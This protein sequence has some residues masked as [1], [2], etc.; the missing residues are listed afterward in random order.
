MALEKKMTNLSAIEEDAVTQ[1]EGLLI[2]LKI[3]SK[4]MINVLTMMAEDFLR[5]APIVVRT[6]EGHL[7]SVQ[8]SLKLPV[9]YLID[10]IVKN[11]GQE[12][13]SLFTQN[14]VSTFCGVFEKVDDKVK[15][16]MFKLRQTWNDHFPQRKLYAIDV[17]CHQFDKNWPISAPPPSNTS[18]IHV[19]P[20]FLNTTTPAIKTLPPKVSPV[21]AGVVETASLLDIGPVPEDVDEVHLRET[22]LQKRKELL[23]LQQKKIELELMQT[24]SALESKRLEEIQS[25]VKQEK[26]LLGQAEKAKSKTYIAHQL[27]SN[28][29]A[30]IVKTGAHPSTPPQPVQ[31]QVALQSLVPAPPVKMEKNKWEADKDSSKDR[32]KDKEREN[33]RGERDRSGSRG[34]RTSSTSS[35]KDSKDHKVRRNYNKDDH[36]N[37]RSMSKSTSKSPTRPIAI[38]KEEVSDHNSS[39]SSPRHHRS[40]KSHHKKSNSGSSGLED[41]LP[42][43]RK[44]EE[45]EEKSPRRKHNRSSSK[46][47][48]ASKT[49]RGGNDHNRDGGEDKRSS[50]SK[51]HAKKSAVIK[52][53]EHE[54]NFR[55]RR[56]AV[57]KRN[58]RKTQGIDMD[59]DENKIPPQQQQQMQISSAEDPSSNNTNTI[60][61]DLRFH[62]RRGGDTDMQQQDDSPNNC[63]NNE[64]LPKK[65]R[66][67]GNGN[68]IVESLFGREDV[69]L[70]QTPCG[71]WMGP[72][73]G[74]HPTPWGPDHPRM[75]MRG[76]ADQQQW[77][78][79][80]PLLR[81]GPRGPNPFEEALDFPRQP[82]I[83]REMRPA[84]RDGPWLPNHPRM[85]Q[86]IGDQWGLAPPPRGPIGPNPFEA[87]LD[88][89]HFIPNPTEMELRIMNE[90]SG[91]FNKALRRG[92]RGQRGSRGR[93]G[94][95][96]GGFMEQHN[97][98][99]DQQQHQLME[100][101]NFPFAINNNLGNNPTPIFP[102]HGHD[103]QQRMARD[104]FNPFIHESPNNNDNGE[105]QRAPLNENDPP[106]LG[107]L[108]VSSLLEQAVSLGLLPATSSEPAAK[109]AGAE[110][111]A[112]V[113]EEA[114]VVLNDP[115][116]ESA[117]SKYQKY[118]KFQRNNHKKMMMAPVQATPPP[119]LPTVDVLL[120]SEEKNYF[121]ERRQGLINQLWVGKQCATCGLRF[122]PD[123]NA[124]YEQHLDW[125][126]RRNARSRKEKED[127]GA[128]KPQRR[129]WYY[130]LPEW[131]LFEEIEDIEERAASMFETQGDADATTQSPGGIV[132]PEECS[133]PAS[134]HTGSV[135]PQ[136]G[137]NFESYYDQDKEEW[138]LRNAV[139]DSTEGEDKDYINSSMMTEEA[140]QVDEI[141]S[142]TVDDVQNG[143]EEVTE[144]ASQQD[145]SP[146]P[147][148]ASPL[149]PQLEDDDDEVLILKEGKK[150]VL[151]EVMDIDDV[152]DEGEG[153]KE[154]ENNDNEKNKEIEI[155]PEEI[156]TT[157]TAT[158]STSDDVLSNADRLPVLNYSIISRPIS[159]P[160]VVNDDSSSNLLPGISEDSSGGVFGFALNLGNIRER[161]ESPEQVDEKRI[162]YK[163]MEFDFPKIKIE[164]PDDYDDVPDDVVSTP[165]LMAMPTPIVEL[166]SDQDPIDLT[167]EDDSVD[168]C[169]GPPPRSLHQMTSIDGNLHQE[170]YVPIIV[171]PTK[172]RINISGLDI[173]AKSPSSKDPK[174][175]DPAAA[176]AASP[177]PEKGSTSP[178]SP[179]TTVVPRS[180]EPSD[181]NNKCSNAEVMSP[182]EMKYLKPRLHEFFE[183]G[184]K[185]KNCPPKQGKKEESGLCVIS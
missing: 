2:E 83:E 161:S 56:S 108:D 99:G 53:Q 172:M 178:K 63:Q 160:I 21:V 96:R 77:G 131:I 68:V 139:V 17:R 177:T 138:R 16:Q 124:K 3:N 134:S 61:V 184:R 78:P 94:G 92:G 6:I 30:N 32:T 142:V 40:P 25:T 89:G 164:P 183:S 87:A 74:P 80:P 82:P 128:K 110:I 28:A 36:E 60:D 12:Y 181:S 22:L 58:Y 91:H 100:M 126:F 106:A 146:P 185:F 111:K 13:P 15:L 141:S 133:V 107:I 180:P 26:L 167:G 52:A 153:E 127:T 39:S 62:G 163:S 73:G 66:L 31:V 147:Q 51:Q 129:A 162:V 41:L 9:L 114:K 105:Q 102:P 37:K 5:Q 50:T 165:N 24:K 151:V 64:S 176:G 144:Q 90:R 112:E 42:I 29:A 27:L 46:E 81:P 33:H 86:H 48:K 4:P 130:K 168:E 120:V 49:T 95:G 75:M 149:P 175:E 170:V 57:L 155:G 18:S 182:E 44:G 169:D 38:I 113:V 79:P 88:Q 97:M 76:G 116:K 174:P 125:H 34:K 150:E 154:D 23:E 103:Q 45:S 140:M 109:E 118:Q 72:A 156:N 122:P 93:G 84:D 65:P 145:S 54:N 85:N 1:F 101:R 11:V 14:I 152:D 67:A 19:N 132:S 35:S 119:P 173:S 55:A 166:S 98:M 157:A 136:C 171:P 20:K 115:P 148:E 7:N 159:S 71:N 47:S 70:R 43:S 8:P 117:I 69:D 158:E 135:C 10:S 179:T 121:K 123:Q 137:E 143:T 104:P 59:D